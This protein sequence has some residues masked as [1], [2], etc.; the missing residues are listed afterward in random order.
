M[1]RHLRDP[2]SEAREP[3]LDTPAHVTKKALHLAI[4]Q[5]KARCLDTDFHKNLLFHWVS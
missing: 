5:T 3:L 1:D 4:A 2:P